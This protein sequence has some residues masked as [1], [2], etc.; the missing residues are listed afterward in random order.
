MKIYLREIK[1]ESTEFCYSEKD[2]WLSQLIL[3]LD[4]KE[5]PAVAER[6]RK[7]AGLKPQKADKIA[8]PIKAKVDLRRLEGTWLMQGRITTSIDLLCSRCASKVTYPVDQPFT[9]VYSQDRAMT[10]ETDDGEIIFLT[11]NF[12]ELDPILTEQVRLNLPYHSLC[13][14]DCKGLCQNCGADLNE[15][16]CA[17]P[18]LRTKSSFSVLKDYKVKITK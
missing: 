14:E 5:D 13:R 11:E 15:G 3:S 12:I 6:I 17:C 18:D 16:R 9:L 10:G 2:A 8:R 7:L 1:E 4:E